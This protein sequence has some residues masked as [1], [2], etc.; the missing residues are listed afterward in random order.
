MIIRAIIGMT[1]GGGIGFAVG[2]FMRR[3]GGGGG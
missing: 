2:Y 1:A 3:C